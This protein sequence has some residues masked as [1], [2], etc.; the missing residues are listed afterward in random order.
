MDFGRGR[1]GTVGRKRVIV[2]NAGTG[3]MRGIIGTLGTPFRLTRED[4][5]PPDPG[6][7]FVYALRAGQSLSLIVRVAPTRPGVYRDRFRV[8][9]SDPTRRNAY[10]S[11]RAEGCSN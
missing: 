7:I 6:G 5:I 3:T 11:V 10:M 2:R 4:G 9:S 8:T 1:V